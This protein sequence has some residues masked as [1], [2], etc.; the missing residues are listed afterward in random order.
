MP[1]RDFLANLQDI[2]GCELVG[3]CRISNR[4]NYL[5]THHGLVLRETQS[6]RL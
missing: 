1:Y 2:F 5:I 4:L 3:G 6:K